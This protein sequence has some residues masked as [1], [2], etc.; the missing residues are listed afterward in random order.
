[1][2][3]SL[4]LVVIK[5]IYSQFKNVKSWAFKEIMSSALTALIEK[6]TACRT[7]EQ[8]LPSESHPI[9]QAS[10]QARILIAGQAPG[11]AANRTG[12]PFDDA[13]GERL[14]DW[15]GIS[16]QQ[17][18]DENLFAILPMAF[19]YP[20]KGKNGD[21]PPRKECV[22]QWRSS[23]L[24]RLPNIQLTLVIGMYAQS[25]HCQDNHSLTERVQH[26]QDYGKALIPLPH[27][28]PR[29]NIWLKRNQWFE[30]QLLPELQQRIRQVLEEG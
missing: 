3:S 30:Q 29:N 20:G 9:I 5:S 8:Y 22:A 6:I 18:Y 4:W 23:L 7:C 15:L 16:K 19:C 11:A 2:F 27:P 21:L 26:W 28:S 14:R 10:S 17:F 13:S 25:Y 12:I 24:D 1:M